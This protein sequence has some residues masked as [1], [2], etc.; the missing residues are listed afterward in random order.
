MKN[1]ENKHRNQQA[2]VKDKGDILAKDSKAKKFHN[3]E[4][5][6]TES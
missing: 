3:P 1:Q 2:V 6:N 4:F 5:G